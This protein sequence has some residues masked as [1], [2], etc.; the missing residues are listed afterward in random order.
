[1]GV[2]S[3][4][5]IYLSIFLIFWISFNYLKLMRADNGT[6]KYFSI[7]D[8][9]IQEKLFVFAKNETALK[10]IEWYKATD[11]IN[12]KIALAI[13]LKSEIP[14]AE[15]FFNC[16]QDVIKHYNKSVKALKQCID[17][18]PTSFMARLSVIKGVNVID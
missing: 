17:V 4:F 14:E 12:R 16:M 1:M 6:K 8:K 3:L 18:F 7:F 10:Y 5:F 13:A 11:D 2:I 15:Q 9:N